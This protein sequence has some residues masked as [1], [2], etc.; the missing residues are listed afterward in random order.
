MAV[1][2]KDSLDSFKLRSYPSETD[3]TEDSINQPTKDNEKENL[4]K[5][6]DGLHKVNSFNL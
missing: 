2:L 3:I 1:E 4:V 5:E 6:N